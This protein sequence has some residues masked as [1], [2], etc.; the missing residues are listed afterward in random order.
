MSLERPVDDTYLLG[1]PVPPVLLLLPE[2]LRYEFHDSGTSVWI[3]RR[4]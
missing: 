3:M 2:R 4:V 1:Y